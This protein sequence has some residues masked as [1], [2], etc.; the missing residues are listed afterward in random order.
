MKAPVEHVEHDLPVPKPELRFIL[1]DG[2]TAAGP[3][4]SNHERRDLLTHHAGDLGAVSRQVLARPGLG[5]HSF[6][7][8]LRSDRPR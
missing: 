4:A 8:D 3:S 6:V 7:A 2:S 1:G 5:I